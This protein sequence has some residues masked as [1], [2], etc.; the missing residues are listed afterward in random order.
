MDPATFIKNYAPKG[1]VIFINYEFSLTEYFN[2]SEDKH[3]AIY[4][5]SECTSNHVKMFLSCSKFDEKM[6]IEA[7]YKNGVRLVNIDDLIKGAISVKVLTLNDVISQYKMGLAA[8]NA[9]SFL[10]MPYGFGN[11][12]IYC[13]KLVADSYKFLGITLPTYNIL[14]KQIFLSQSFVN[15]KQWKIVYSFLR[16]T[17]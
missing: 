4:I 3:A 12:N 16:P 11:D 8:D 17:D 5:G 13:F 2:P 9:M 6:A 7:S 15:N 1:A 14:G 10:G